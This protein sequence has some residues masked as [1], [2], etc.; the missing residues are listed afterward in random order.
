MTIDVS[1]AMRYLGAAGDSSLRADLTP[2]ADEL[3]AR[4]TPRWVWRAFSKEEM[5]LPGHTAAIM[6]RECRRV[7][8][9][10]A[11]LGAPFDAWMRREQKRDMRRA[12]LLDALGSAY[13]EA[14]CDAAA[15]EIAGRFPG[16]YPTDRFSP[17][18]GDLPLHA[19]HMLLDAVDAARAVGVTLTDTLMMQPQKSVS[20]VIGLAD[21]PQMARIRGCDHCGM[22]GTCPLR[23]VGKRCDI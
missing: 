9:L 13:I 19:Q 23:K 17:G 6:L 5:P 15:E 4:I 18:Y 8:V 21:T 3:T 10:C 14:A 7:I 2:L 16:Q 12:V 1:E 22:N 11:T 20:A